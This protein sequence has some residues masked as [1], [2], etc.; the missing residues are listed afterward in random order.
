MEQKQREERSS[1]GMGLVFFLSDHIYIS[2][3]EDSMV[4]LCQA[5]DG[6]RLWEATDIMQFKISRF[7]KML[8]FAIF[9][10]KLSCSM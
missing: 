2:P 6:K 7:L 9:A 8:Y 3:T 1:H 10:A 4:W 5:E